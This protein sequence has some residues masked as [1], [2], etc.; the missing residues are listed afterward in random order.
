MRS[1]AS[2]TECGE[3]AKVSEIDCSVEM[4]RERKQRRLCYGVKA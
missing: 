2:Q 1:V 4:R 3:N